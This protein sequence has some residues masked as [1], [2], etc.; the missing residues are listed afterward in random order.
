MTTENKETTAQARPREAAPQGQRGTAPQR[1][2]GP[3]GRGG[4]RRGGGGRPRYFARRKVCNFCVGHVKR[5][6]YKEPALL[7]NYT[8]DRSK[9][10]TRRKTGTCAKHQRAL[11][12]AIKRARFLALLPASPTHFTSARQSR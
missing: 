11:A 1:S 12:Q 4:F 7:R 5:I 6:D 8:S 10:E 3:P 2:D 9:I